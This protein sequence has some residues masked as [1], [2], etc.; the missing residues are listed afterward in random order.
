M[1]VDYQKGKYVF[2]SKMWATVFSSKLGLRQ[3]MMDLKLLKA[4][5]A[6]K[7]RF[8]F[9]LWRPKVGLLAGFRKGCLAAKRWE[10]FHLFTLIWWKW[11]LVLSRACPTQDLL[12]PFSVHHFKSR[13]HLKLF[14]RRRGASLTHSIV[15]IHRAPAVHGDSTLDNF[16]GTAGRLARRKYYPQQ[17]VILKANHTQIIPTCF[18]S[19]PEDPSTST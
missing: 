18:R 6:G 13:P 17:F 8:L 2:F 14:H 19:G 12:R 16:S 1:G 15:Q 10:S 3:T 4:L 7:T 11:C 9:H 5:S